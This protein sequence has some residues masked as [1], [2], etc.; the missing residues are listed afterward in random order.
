MDRENS[1]PERR[2]ITLPRH[3]FGALLILFGGYIFFDKV[4]RS[5]QT[6]EATER[7]GLLERAIEPIF[8]WASVAFNGFFGTL[9]AMAGLAIIIFG[10]AK[11]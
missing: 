3:L 7:I 6:G 10:F 11:K 5:L 9:I 2:R 4:V 1:T 8:F